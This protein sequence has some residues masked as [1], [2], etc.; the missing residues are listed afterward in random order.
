M[1]FCDR[2][3]RLNLTEIQ[4]AI[5]DA[6]DRDV[7]RILDRGAYRLEDF[8]ALIS[9]A[10]SAHLERMARE[11]RRITRLRF[12][13][14][15]R[16][17]APLYISNECVNAC[18]YCGF[19]VRNRIERVTLTLQEVR[20]QAAILHRHGFRHLLLVSGEAPHRV[21]L[22]LLCEIAGALSRDFSAL[23]IEVYPL[24][25][26][27]YRRL[28]RA[29]IT[30]IAV[31]QETYSRGLYRTLHRGP[32][33]DFE[34]R[35]G[36]PER[37]GEAGFREIGI[38]ALLGLWDFRVETTCVAMHAAYLMKRFWKA[39]VAVS[40]P[41]LR[42]AEGAFSPLAPVSDRDL[43]QAVF[44]LRMVFPDVD[45]VLSTREHPA[46]R[47]G[48]AGLGITRM[49]AGSRTSPGG[50]EAEEEPLQQFEVADPRSPAEVAE[51]LLA[52]GLEPVWKDFDPAFLFERPPP[53]GGPSPR[54]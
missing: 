38:G 5:G 37:A 8:P 31:Y 18:A 43:A 17:Y 4:E 27:A 22:D 9:P 24:D 12:G 50:Y 11:A 35:L 44:A 46:F 19:N 20:E 45:L 39:Q 49:S 28:A 25:T 10:A 26:D 3:D 54:G 14:V 23:S 6:S 52:R 21:P 53:I 7:E 51:M 16:L 48:L 1:T 29:G 34:Y 32:K 15:V 13:K 42:R 41:R 36:T 33:A 2:F 30:G 47:D 40:F